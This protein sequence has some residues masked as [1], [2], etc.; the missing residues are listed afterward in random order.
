MFQVTVRLALRDSAVE[1]HPFD[2]IGQMVEA[3][4]QTAGMIEA[5][6][7]LDPVGACHMS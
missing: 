5:F 2:R 4:Q 1:N 6:G 3:L 7:F